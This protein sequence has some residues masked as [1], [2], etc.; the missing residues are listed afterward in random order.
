MKKLSFV[1]PCYRSENTIEMVINE[2]KEVLF[3]KPEYDYEIIAVNDCSPDNVLAVL[4]GIAGENTKVKVIDFMSNSGK[5]SAIMAGVSV[6]DGDIIVMMDDDFQCPVTEVWNLIAPIESGE[7]DASSARYEKK[8]EN[9]FK[10]FCS[11]IYTFFAHS[12]LGQPKNV[13]IE[14]Y[15]AVS[16][17]ICKEIRS[18]KNPYPFID[19]LILRATKK[20]AM[21]DMKERTRGD[22]NPT[23]FTFI[24]SMR[25]F[26]D[27]VTAFS[28]QPLRIATYLGISIALF[29]LTYIVITIIRFFAL[30]VDPG[31]S[32]LL[33]VLLFIGG[34]L[35]VMLGIVGEYVGRIYM[36]INQTPQYVIRR[37]INFN[38]DENGSSI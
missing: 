36:C 16:K 13:V 20:I 23:G 38:G 27:G 6:A 22:D 34:M 14:N 5:Y 1:I 3:Q 4:E 17:A 15:L 26:L 37:T 12:M 32:S 18:C 33:S 31:Y 7:Y 10:R 2:I 35:M 25:M 8:M 28:I 29:G 9:A 19:G 24:K 11:K 30:S 21:V